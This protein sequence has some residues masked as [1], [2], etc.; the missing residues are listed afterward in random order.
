MK[1]LCIIYRTFIQKLEEKC[2]KILPYHIGHMLPPCYRFY[3]FT[4]WCWFCISPH[5]A[6]LLP[7]PAICKWGTECFHKSI[8]FKSKNSVIKTNLIRLL[9]VAQR[10]PLA[11]GEAASFGTKKVLCAFL[12][13]PTVYVK[14]KYL[15]AFPYR[16]RSQRRREPQSNGGRGEFSKFADENWR[17]HTKGAL[18]VVT[19]GSCPKRGSRLFAHKS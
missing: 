2:K 15:S 1:F 12:M 17:E 19:V 7:E 9:Q 3:I 4:F 6:I 14:I 10:T 8:F 11:P 16:H 5:A 18:R 13:Q